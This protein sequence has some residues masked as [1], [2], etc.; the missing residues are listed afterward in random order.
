[1]S[2]AFLYMLKN[3]STFKKSFTFKEYVK[4]ISSSV[5]GSYRISVLIFPFTTRRL[6]MSSPQ[7]VHKP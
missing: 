4:K 7:V 6:T 1:M 3:H 5:Y 2:F